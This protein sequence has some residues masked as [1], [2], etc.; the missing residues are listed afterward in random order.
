MIVTADLGKILG[1][2]WIR[3]EDIRLRERKFW[4]LLAWSFVFSYYSI[5]FL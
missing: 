3:D 5:Y 2:F 1:G 4:D